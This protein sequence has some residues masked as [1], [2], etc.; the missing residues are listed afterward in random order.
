MSTNH[1][2][3]TTISDQAAIQELWK[4][5]DRKSTGGVTLEQAKI[6][7]KWGGISVSNLLE[8]AILVNNKKL[9]K[10]NNDGEDY[11]DGSDAKYMTARARGHGKN[12]KAKNNAA[13]LSPD[14]LKNKHGKLR[15]FITHLDE[16][17]DKINYRMFL[18]P[19]HEWK[20][21]MLKG[22]V[23]FAF[24]PKTGDLAPRSFKRWGDFE[25]KSFKDLCK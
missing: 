16:R 25:V 14:A 1:S 22:G 6:L 23:D 7:A 21:R 18:I 17:R 20:T 4:K 12:G 19:L 10:S 11:T 3:N 24:S 15:I 13:V 5:L 2:E 9:K 8:Q